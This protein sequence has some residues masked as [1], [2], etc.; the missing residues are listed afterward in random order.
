M[1][2]FRVITCSDVFAWIWT[3]TSCAHTCYKILISNGPCKVTQTN[4]LKSMLCC[5][6]I[7]LVLTLQP[8][9]IY[10]SRKVRQIFDLLAKLR[11][12]WKCASNLFSVLICWI[13]DTTLFLLCIAAFSVYAKHKDDKFEKILIQNYMLLYD[14]F[15]LDFVARSHILELKSL[16]QSKKYKLY[17]RRFISTCKLIV[18]GLIKLFLKK[19]NSMSYLLNLALCVHEILHLFVGFGVFVVDF[20]GVILILWMCKSQICNVIK[21]C[22]TF[23][24]AVRNREYK[25]AWYI[26][27]DLLYTCRCSILDIPF[28]LPHKVK[29]FLCGKF[30]N[31][32]LFSYFAIRFIYSAWFEL[33][34]SFEWNRNFDQLKIAI[35]DVNVSYANL[36]EFTEDITAKTYQACL[37]IFMIFYLINAINENDCAF[38]CVDFKIASSSC[39]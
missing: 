2:L 36:M 14:I 1:D 34:S 28:Q 27:M 17:L 24:S 20:V 30:Y 13:L 39:A 5:C 26:I 38:I 21:T 23:I 32:V 35:Q 8:L 29:W 4:K 3:P 19:K 18:T 11:F 33:V 15:R 16:S 12:L 37:L 10:I 22:S 6:L 9:I 25:R 31:C 7:V